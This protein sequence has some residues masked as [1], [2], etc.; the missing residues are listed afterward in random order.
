MFIEHG[1]IGDHERATRTLAARV[2]F[3]MTEF[4]GLAIEHR[5]HRSTAGH[6]QIIVRRHQCALQ[7]N[8]GERQRT[9]RLFYIR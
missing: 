7:T 5:W 6:N 9:V 3:E 1:I 4:A 8:S 2:Q